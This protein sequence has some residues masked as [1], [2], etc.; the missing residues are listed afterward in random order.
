MTKK[1]SIDSI[2]PLSDGEIDFEDALSEVEQIVSRLEAGDLGLTESLGQYEIGVRRLKQCHQLLGAAEQRVSVLAGFD[3][4]GNPVA[5]PLADLQV[6]G[7]S[8]SDSEAS[9]TKASPPKK[10]VRAKKKAASSIDGDENSLKTDEN[11][12]GVDGA[13]GLF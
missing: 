6:R 9:T 4:E 13:S 10:P 1:K 11:G 7:G 3:A 2:S 12:D 8:R 5:E